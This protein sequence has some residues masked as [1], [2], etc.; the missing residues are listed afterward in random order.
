MKKE[1]IPITVFLDE[2]EWIV[3]YASDDPNTGKVLHF[4]KILKNIRERNNLPPTV[5]QS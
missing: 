5:L 4:D 2:I 1:R 3:G